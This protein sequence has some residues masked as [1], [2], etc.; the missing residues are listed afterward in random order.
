[1]SV[2]WNFSPPFL[3]LDL[4]ISDS[5]T[6]DRHCSFPTA[7]AVSGMWPMRMANYAEWQTTLQFGTVTFWSCSDWRKRKRLRNSEV[8]WLLFETDRAFLWHL[9]PTSVPQI[10]CRMT[11]SSCT[12]AALGVHV[13]T[14]GSAAAA[15]PNGLFAPPGTQQ[16]GIVRCC[17][18]RALLYQLSLWGPQGQGKALY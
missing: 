10:C 18:A 8:P 12:S 17:L 3:S 13:M 4:Y 5:Q 16:D 6:E 9:F 11:V 1:M 7:T 2:G 15:V 14:S